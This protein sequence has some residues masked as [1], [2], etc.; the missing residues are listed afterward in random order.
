MTERPFISGLKA[1]AGGVETGWPTVTAH[2]YCQE[3]GGEGSIVVQVPGGYFSSAQEQWYPDERTEACDACNGR[4]EVE[5]TRCARC[6][7]DADDCD[8]DED[9]VRE[10][11]D[12]VLSAKP[13]ENFTWNDI[14]FLA[15]LDGKAPEYRSE[16]IPALLIGPLQ[17]VRVTRAIHTEGLYEFVSEYYEG[18]P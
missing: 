5:V 4:G 2:E 12:W 16:R 13:N 8:C 3:C 6:G 15:S 11:L 17:T 7:V 18:R 9:A 10:W 14:H 1:Q